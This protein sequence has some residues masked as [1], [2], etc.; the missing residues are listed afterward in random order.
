MKNKVFLRHKQTLEYYSGSTEWVSDGARAHDFDTVANAL[1]WARSQ[2]L[3][4][5][6]VVLRYETPACELV[7]PIRR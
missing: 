2:N 4:D 6:E 7:L 3:S 5:V 1:A